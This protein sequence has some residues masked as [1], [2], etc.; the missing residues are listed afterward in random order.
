MSKFNAEC[1]FINYEMNIWHN[2]LQHNLGTSEA[3]VKPV[4]SVGDERKNMLL[5]WLNI[6]TEPLTYFLA[7]H[8]GWEPSQA[9]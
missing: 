6:T 2:R 3:A 1:I 7:A 8:Q 5:W 9:V 4:S